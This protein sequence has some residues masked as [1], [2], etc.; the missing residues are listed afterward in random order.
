MLTQPKKSAVI[1]ARCTPSE[2][3]AIIARARRAN[4]SVSAYL[5]G[6]AMHFADMPAQRS[7]IGQPAKAAPSYLRSS[8]GRAGA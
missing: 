5:I 7:P 1:V 2:R 8:D 4:K 3:E 6:C